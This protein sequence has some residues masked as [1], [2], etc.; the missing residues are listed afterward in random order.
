MTRLQGNNAVIPSGWFRWYLVRDE[1]EA[2]KIAAGRAD[3][4]LYQSMIIP[5]LYLLVPELTRFDN[6]M[7]GY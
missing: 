6:L 5:A 2:L 3:C 7:K 4:I 1:A